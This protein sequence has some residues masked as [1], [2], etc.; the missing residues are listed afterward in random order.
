M[1]FSFCLFPGF[2]LYVSLYVACISACPKDKLSKIPQVLLPSVEEVF[3]FYIEE[4]Y[5]EILVLEKKHG[6]RYS[7]CLDDLKMFRQECPV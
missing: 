2:F 7:G 6:G 1:A 3:S 5:E 4:K